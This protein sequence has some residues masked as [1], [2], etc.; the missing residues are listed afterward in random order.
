LPTTKPGSSQQREAAYLQQQQNAAA[1]KY[2]KKQNSKDYQ[3]D[4]ASNRL[5]HVLCM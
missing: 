2:A 4:V 3:A 5:L 1:R